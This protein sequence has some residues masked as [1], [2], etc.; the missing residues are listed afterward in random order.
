MLVLTRKIQEQIQIGDSITIT[1]LRMKGQ[2]VRVGIDAPEDVRIVRGELR[3]AMRQTIRE[4]LSMDV[5]EKVLDDG[6]G[7]A[8][9]Q[10]ESRTLPTERA[11][12]Q[13]PEA[14]ESKAPR[15]ESSSAR[16][17]AGIKSG[18]PGDCHDRRFSS[19]LLAIAT[20]RM[21]RRRAH[22]IPE[23]RI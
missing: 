21:R 7:S 15:R 1:I 9:N 16:K 10:P 11:A 5:P 13:S 20:R 12:G 3:R 22:F 2:A 19:P 4:E 23:G 18:A 14:T 8:S 17:R 6:R